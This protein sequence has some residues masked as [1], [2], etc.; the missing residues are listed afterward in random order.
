MATID[1]TKVKKV[2]GASDAQQANALIAKGWVL[3]ETASGKDEMG[4]PLTTY[5]LAWM[6]DSEPP[7]DY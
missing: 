4:Y 5:S 1:L 2:R 3:I 6:G 7:Q